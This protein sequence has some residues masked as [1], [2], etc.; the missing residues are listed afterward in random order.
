MHAKIA[1]RQDDYFSAPAL[2]GEVLGPSKTFK[3]IEIPLKNTKIMSFEQFQG[4]YQSDAIL[5]IPS[6]LS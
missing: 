4:L 3:N 1:R 5:V 6:E 2:L